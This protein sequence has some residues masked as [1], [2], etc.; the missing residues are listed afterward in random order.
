MNDKNFV[1]Y[2]SFVVIL[3]FTFAPIAMASEIKG[4]AY[5]LNCDGMPGRAIA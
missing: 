3:F 1:I 4:N 5:S 2:L